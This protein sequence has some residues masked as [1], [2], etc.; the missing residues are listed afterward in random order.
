MSYTLLYLRQQL[1]QSLD[2]LV[3]I[4]AT[5]GTTTTIVDTQR[6][7]SG[8]FPDDAFV[9]ATV[10]C[11]A[12][13]DGLAPKGQARYV[14]DFVAAT[15][16]LTVGR[17]FTAAVDPNDAFDI[18]T[19]Y[20]DIE[21]N[22]ALSF[23]VRDWRLIAV[24]TSVDTT[25]YTLTGVG[26]HHRGQIANV[27]ARPKDDQ[28]PW[29]PVPNWRVWQDGPTLLLQVPTPIPAD[30]E[31]RVEYQALYDQL[32]SGAQFDDTKVAGGDLWRHLL[33]AQMH[34]YRIKMQSES[35]VDR[36]WYAS[37]YREAVERLQQPADDGRR[38]SR[39]KTTDWLLPP[40]RRYQ[41]DWWL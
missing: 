21:L 41:P 1:A 24:T 36:D 34:L 31:L 33:T 26:L 3:Q 4:T 23:A 37:L 25:T 19:R 28:V 40:S 11:T 35:G 27:L 16:T 8:E 18:Y 39:A 2:S 7:D 29:A 13:S 10:Y 32:K 9:G 15:G 22:T 38:A 5:S 12:T 14:T 17:P 20:T 6:L 30:Y